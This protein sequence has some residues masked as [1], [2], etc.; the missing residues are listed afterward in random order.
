MLWWKVHEANLPNLAPFAK[1]ILA[2]PASSAK[3]ERVFSTG[4]NIVTAKRSSQNPEKVECQILIKENKEQLKEFE[5]L[6]KLP[7]KKS[8]ISVFDG[9]EINTTSLQSGPS[10]LPSMVFD[11]GDSI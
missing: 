1:R 6:N 11:S 2:I 3:S 10:L 9:I 5:R 4:G 7:L 8:S